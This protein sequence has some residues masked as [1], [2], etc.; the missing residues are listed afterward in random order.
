MGLSDYQIARI[1]NNAARAYCR[2]MKIPEP[3]DWDRS[4]SAERSS[5]M[6]GPEVVRRNPD[7]TAEEIHQKWFE[8]M[9]K[10]GFT[11]GEEKDWERKTHPSLRP[12]K[13]LSEADRHI[14]LITLAVI[15]ALVN[16]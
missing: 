13:E 15:K 4:S 11:V 3:L 8:H 16:A 9:I 12:F 10:H 5:M 7:I 6:S 2:V 1:A 14:D